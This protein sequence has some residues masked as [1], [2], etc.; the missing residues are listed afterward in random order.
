V[1]RCKPFKLTSVTLL[2]ALILCLDS[3]DTTTTSCW[4]YNKEGTTD[5]S[6]SVIFTTSHIFHSYR[7]IIQ[8]V[9]SDQYEFAWLMN[10]IRLTRSRCG[11]SK[12]CWSRK[13][14]RLAEK[15]DLLIL[16]WRLIQSLCTDNET[17]SVLRVTWQGHLPNNFVSYSNLSRPGSKPY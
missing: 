14:Y 10:G 6:I 8:F 16:S 17:I 12:S 4:G 7:H 2:A 13:Y 9:I 11:G 5:Q 3:A 15:A 1:G